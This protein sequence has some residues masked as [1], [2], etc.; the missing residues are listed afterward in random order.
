MTSS[1]DSLKRNF[2]Q[3]KN[4]FTVIT[5]SLE[6]TSDINKQDKAL[7]QLLSQMDCLLKEGSLN[8]SMLSSSD[9]TALQNLKASYQDLEKE[10][11]QIKV[12]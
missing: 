12:H 10:Y 7:Q 2:K 4:S 5:S 1:I 8:Y 9:K 3:L 6:N 11:R